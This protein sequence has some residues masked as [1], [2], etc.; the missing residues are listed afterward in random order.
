M[1]D[2]TSSKLRRV[3]GKTTVEGAR[4]SGAVYVQPIDFEGK[5]LELYKVEVAHGR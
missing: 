2:E 5:P 1:S 3:Y 4:A